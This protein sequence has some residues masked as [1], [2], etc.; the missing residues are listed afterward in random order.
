[1]LYVIKIPLLNCLWTFL[2]HL[3]LLFFLSEF[4]VDKVS[5]PLETTVLKFLEQVTSPFETTIALKVSLESS[6]ETF[7][8][9]S[10]LKQMLWSGVHQFMNSKRQY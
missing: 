10:Q 4:Q 3:G 7:L 9:L 2:F 8:E 1:M 5:L 6:E